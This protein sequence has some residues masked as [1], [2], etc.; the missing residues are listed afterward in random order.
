M[1]SAWIWIWFW[2]FFFFFRHRWQQIVKLLPNC[3]LKSRGSRV[4]GVCCNAQRATA[5]A[6]GKCNCLADK[7]LVHYLRAFFCCFVLLCFVLRF[8]DVCILCMVTFYSRHPWR[9]RDMALPA[10]VCRLDICLSAAAPH[11]NCATALATTTEIHK[12]KEN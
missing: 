10:S 11:N 3:H 12:A 7:S 9:M 6:T 2:L 4:E 5:T 8:F 1:G